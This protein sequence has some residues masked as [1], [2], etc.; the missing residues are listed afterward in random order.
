M[1]VQDDADSNVARTGAFG[2][3]EEEGD[4]CDSDA[5]LELDIEDQELD[6]AAEEAAELDANGYDAS[7]DFLAPDDDAEAVAPEPVDAP[8]PAAVAGVGGAQGSR[9]SKRRRK[10][11]VLADE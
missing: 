6:E 9:R 11:R 5:D 8:E 10:R 3:A 7:D 2:A 4:A 1:G